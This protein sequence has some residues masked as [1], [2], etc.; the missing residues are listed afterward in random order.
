MQ[1]F[2]DGSCSLPISDFFEYLEEV[3]RDR[4]AR[5]TYEE[6][7]EYLGDGNGDKRIKHLL[8]MLYDVLQENCGS[9]ADDSDEALRYD[10]A[11]EVLF[12]IM[13]EPYQFLKTEEQA[14][15]IDVMNKITDYTKQGGRG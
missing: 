3:R 11:V 4:K 6:I 7:Q 2:R 12:Q 5:K 1:S 13:I 10:W 14:D 15:Y 9:Y 8:K